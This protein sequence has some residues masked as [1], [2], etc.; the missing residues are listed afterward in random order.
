MKDF[1]TA[2]GLVMILEGLPY[3]ISPATMKEWIQKLN[4]IPDNVIRQGALVS[5]FVGLFIVY[6]MRG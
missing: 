1:F 4:A 2:L 6:L 5:M 3:F